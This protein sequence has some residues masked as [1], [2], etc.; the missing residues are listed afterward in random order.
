M[1]SG[2]VSQFRRRLLIV[3][4]LLCILL[5]FFHVRFSNNLSQQRQFHS[6]SAELH[7]SLADVFAIN[8]TAE[9]F[10]LMGKKVAT[11]ADLAEHYTSRTSLDNKLLTA[12]V[13]EQFPWWN[14]ET[15]S[16]F[17]W[18]PQTWYNAWTKDL[19]WL[20]TGIV[21]C[22]GNKNA[23]EAAFLIANL[24]NVLHC[25]LPIQIAYNGDED[26][27]LRSRQ[28]LEKTGN[29]VSCLDLT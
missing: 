18:K 5:F 10:G 15:L 8:T 16:Y 28:F 4:V 9:D 3:L 27:S 24:R 11:L 21:V 1:L 20:N 26:L 22:A 12:A 14:P 17:P 25:K 29:D 6:T 7:T 13:V 2:L 19:P 23:W